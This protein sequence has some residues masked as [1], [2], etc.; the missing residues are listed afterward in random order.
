MGW[1]YLSIPKLQ[2]C[3]RWSLGMDK[4]F[5]LT[6]YQACNYLSMLGLKLNHVSKRGH[7]WEFVIKTL[8]LNTTWLMTDVWYPSGGRQGALALESVRNSQGPHKM[9]MCQEFTIPKLDLQIR[10]LFSFINHTFFS[11][12]THNETIPFKTNGISWWIL[13]LSPNY[14]QNAKWSSHAAPDMP[15]WIR[16]VIV[17]DI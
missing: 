12:L 7:Q 14:I 3:N 2:R 10:T 4:K 8:P 6:L 1:N 9:F 13:W 16:V 11:I 5:H 15:L 17:C